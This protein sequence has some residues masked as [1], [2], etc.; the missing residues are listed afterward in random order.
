VRVIQRVSVPNGIACKYL[1]T[2]ADGFV[3]EATYIRRPEKHVLCLSTQV[4]CAVGCK[5]CTSGLRGKEAAYQRS[6]T[7]SE[8]ISQCQNVV[9]D[10]DFMA[11]P[12]PILFSFMGEGEPLLNFEACLETFSRV[13][14]MRWPMPLRLAVSTSGVR[15]NLIRRLGKIEFSV[16][17]KLQISLH[18]STDAVRRLIVPNSPPLTEIVDAVSD[19]RDRNT[20]HFDRTIEWNYVLCSE[21]NDR[22]ANAEIL[23]KLLGPGWYVKLNRLNLVSD[24]SFHRRN[25]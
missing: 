16:P 5:F 19:Y 17:F 20:F 9:A 4:G 11:Y 8:M 13:S 21:V 2:T 12:Q 18:G 14:A 10:M 24:S 6:L 23:V 3:V 7:A 1:Q 15:P 22:T 25:G